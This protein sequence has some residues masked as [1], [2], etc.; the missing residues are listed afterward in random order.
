MRMVGWAGNYV[1]FLELP[2]DVGCSSG[3]LTLLYTA[4]GSL[5]IKV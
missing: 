3:S 2:L 1:Y 4:S 5:I